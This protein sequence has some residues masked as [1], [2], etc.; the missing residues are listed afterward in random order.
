MSSPQLQVHKGT[1]IIPIDSS[2]PDVSSDEKKQA[3]L[4]VK[5]EES[6]KSVLDE[7]E[8]HASSD[9]DIHATSLE[10]KEDDKPELDEDQ[11]KEQELEAEKAKMKK[12]QWINLVAGIGVVAMAVIGVFAFSFSI[13]AL[14]VGATALEVSIAVIVGGAAFAGAGLTLYFALIRP[15]WSEKLK[16]LK[17][18]D[19]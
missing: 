18:D 11:K 9:K 2:L 7:T 5:V 15:G 6:A 16:V 10:V 19:K 8:I 4:A 12:Q 13:A 3:E 1:P 17:D 14:V